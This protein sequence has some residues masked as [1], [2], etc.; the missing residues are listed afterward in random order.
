MINIRVTLDPAFVIKLNKLQFAQQFALVGGSQAVYLYLIEYHK[1][2]DWKGE[3]WMPG[4]NSGEFADNVVKGWQPPVIQ[5][6][7][8]TITN[9]FGLLGWKISGGTITPK[10][11]Q[12][13]TIPLIPQAKGIPAGAFGGLFVMGATL[14][15]RIGARIEAIYALRRSVFQAP[16]PDAMPTADQMK[17]E[18]MKGAEAALVREFPP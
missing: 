6:D 7:V 16:W 14:S 3:R 1:A 4:A 8:A 18:F 13:L 9:T 12:A 15:M 10:T 17:E 5:G 2:M 11:A